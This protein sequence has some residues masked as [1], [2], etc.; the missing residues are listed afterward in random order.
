MACTNPFQI[1]LRSNLEWRVILDFSDQ[2]LLTLYIDKAI[3]NLR[4]LGIRSAVELAVIDWENDED[5][6]YFS[7]LDR[8]EVIKRI[9]SSLNMDETATRSLIR[10]IS[11]DATVRFL[12]SLWSYDTPDD[13]I[14][15]EE[16]Q[17][18]TETTQ[19][20]NSDHKESQGEAHRV[21]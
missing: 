3:Q 6:G 1:F 16:D 18:Q 20:P 4:P 17:E 8:N 7:G 10:S 11:D 15:A 19:P 2:A 9:A 14:E 5:E 12:G 13:G 21:S